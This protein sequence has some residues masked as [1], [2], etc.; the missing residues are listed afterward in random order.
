MNLQ[1]KEKSKLVTLKLAAFVFG[2]ILC[3][4]GGGGG[5]SDVPETPSQKPKL[6]LNPFNLTFSK[7]Q[8]DNQELEI[9]T[10]ADATWNISLPGGG[11]LSA[12][13][14]SGRGS[15]TIT[16]T[17]KTENKGSSITDELVVTATNDAGSTSQKIT[18]YREPG[19]ADN[20]YAKI[21]ERIDMSYGFACVIE[22]GNNTKSFRCKVFTDSEYSSL[23]DNVDKIAQESSKWES[24]DVPSSGGIEIVYDKCQPN[25]RYVFV[26]IAFDREGNRGEINQY[27]FSTKDAGESNQPRAE[28]TA[29]PAKVDETHD[30][31]QGPWYKWD[32]TA[33]G[34]CKFYLTYACASDTE[35]DTMRG[36][37]N[38]G[39]INENNIDVVWKIWMESKKDNLQS[40]RPTSFNSNNNGGREILFGRA[41]HND[42]QWLQY[43]NTD[44]YFQIVTWA[45]STDDFTSYSGIVQDVVYKVENGKLIPQSG[46]G[47]NITIGRDDYDDDKSLDDGSPVTYSL[48]VSPASLSY[49]SDGGTKTVTITSN[50]N[51]TIS[52]STSWCT[53]SQSSGSNNGVITISVASNASSSSRTATVTIKGEKGGKTATVNVSQE[54]AETSIGRDEYDK[55]KEIK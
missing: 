40:D 54:G 5:G 11:W 45:F 8:G 13:T 22:A 17:T 14:T 44:K 51:W 23:R 37:N 31:N 27:D 25:S 10:D 49:P 36:R 46:S 32:I 20:C 28:I 6:S 15:R 39:E 3:A 48:S 21:I 29:H 9:T 50:D 41:Y 35:F 42:T 47:D 55:D 24:K 53:I 16:L 38:F 33:N 1:T 7:A 52:S 34:K 18:V 26:T 4:C 12:N 19:I 2:C 30:G 43:R